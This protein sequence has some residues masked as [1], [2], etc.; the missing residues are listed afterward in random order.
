MNAARFPMPS[1]KQA[2]SPI[3]QFS[4]HSLLYAPEGLAVT[5]DKIKKPQQMRLFHSFH[6]FIGGWEYTLH[7]LAEFIKQTGYRVAV[8]DS[9]SV[10][11][12]TFHEIRIR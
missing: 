5:A 12:H 3:L 4:S 10:A 6:L 7:H 2:P 8:F 11:L 1:R 9:F